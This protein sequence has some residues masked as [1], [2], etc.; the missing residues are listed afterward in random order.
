MKNDEVVN[1]LLANLANHANENPDAAFKEASVSL[2]DWIV[3]QEKFTRLFNFPVFAVDGKS[4]LELSSAD[5]RTPPLAPVR[6][7]HK[8]LQPF[9]DLFSPE[10][11]LDDAFFQKVSDQEV[12]K[13]L[14]DLGVVRTDVIISREAMNLNALSLELQGVNEGTRSGC[15][16]K[17]Y[18]FL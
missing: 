5:N 1:K 8:D 17:C 6:S 13:H 18:R 9:A 10:R 7:W 2:F 12:W 14:N 15:P 4:V 16:L 3:S 11:I